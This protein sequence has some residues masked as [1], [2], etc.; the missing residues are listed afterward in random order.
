MLLVFLK[1][2]DEIVER[3]YFSVKE[4]APITFYELLLSTDRI[5]DNNSFMTYR[6][7]SLQNV[8]NQNYER[9]T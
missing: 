6:K 5:T 1:L 7:I 9:Q 8:I 4:T 2:F 3:L